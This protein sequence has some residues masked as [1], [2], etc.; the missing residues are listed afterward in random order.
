MKKIK[1]R[2]LL[3]SREYWMV[4]I[5][6]DLYAV[7][8]EYM[9]KNSLNRTSL[10]EQLQV[11]KGYITQVLKGDFDHKISK[12]VDLSL[13]A[14]KAPVLHFV[15]LNTFIQ[16]DEED[17]TYSLVAHVKPSAG[18]FKKTPPMIYPGKENPASFEI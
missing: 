10:A 2:D 1:R 12:L 8:E 16:N 4:Q 18:R 11:T 14:G 6:Q 9:Q 5:Q 17:Q 7:I 15:D 13:F 3:R